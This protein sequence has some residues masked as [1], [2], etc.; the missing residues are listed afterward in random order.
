MDNSN[1]ER[2]KCQMSDAKLLIAPNCPHCS[3]MMALLGDMVKEG[4]I[5]RLLIINISEEPEEAARHNIRSV[6][7][8]KLGNLEFVGARSREE[9]EKAI[10]QAN[11][12]SGQRRFI[13]D[14]LKGGM[15]EDVIQY[16]GHDRERLV[17]AIALLYEE[18]VPIAV[19]IGVSALVEGLQGS[20]DVLKSIL[21]ELLKLSK[22]ENETIRAD[23]IHF[24]SLVDDE[25]ARE[26][27]RE[28]LDDESA[29][30]REIAGDALA[31]AG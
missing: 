9:L 29:M 18:D 4:A 6:P 16:V 25:P 13:F 5:R 31:D 23:A 10:D 12:E 7:W 30:V 8:V 11:S 26:R 20:P 1:I 24:L 19:R 14:Q 22:V 27:L 15:L 28:C 21:P 3:A 2:R 17:E